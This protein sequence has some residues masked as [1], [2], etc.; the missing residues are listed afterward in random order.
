MSDPLDRVELLHALAGMAEATRQFYQELLNEGFSKQ[1][2]LHLTTAW[3]TAAST[4][5][6][7]G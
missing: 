5:R 6:Q 4:P 2:A 1:E 7:E 3:L